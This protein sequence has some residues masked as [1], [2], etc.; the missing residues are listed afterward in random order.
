MKTPPTRSAAQPHPDWLRDCGFQSRHDPVTHGI[1]PGILSQNIEQP[2]KNALYSFPPVAETES[3]TLPGRQI[4]P[5]SEV[6]RP[7]S[8]SIA[9][10]PPGIA[11]DV[12][13][14]LRTLRQLS[15]GAFCPETSRDCIPEVV[16][17]GLITLLGMAWPILSMLGVMGHHH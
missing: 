12:L 6:A 2:A 10:Q 8:P 17:F 15:A 3:N 11:H 9:K 14:E 4:F 5:L 13:S 16:L 7:K 1:A